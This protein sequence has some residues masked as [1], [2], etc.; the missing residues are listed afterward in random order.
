LSYN[1]LNTG[2]NLTT[3]KKK[4]LIV[5]STLEGYSSRGETIW[6]CFHFKGY[7]FGTKV[8]RILFEGIE[9]IMDQEYFIEAEMIDIQNGEL[10][11]RVTHLNILAE[12]YTDIF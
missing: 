2:F 11:A 12:I 9:A 6:A 10:L 3:F 7:A 8:D 4:S 1:S 5:I